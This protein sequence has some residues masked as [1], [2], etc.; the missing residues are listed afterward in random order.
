MAE[1]LSSRE[2]LMN[3]WQTLSYTNQKEAVELVQ[4]AKKPETRERRISKPSKWR[5]RS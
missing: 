4:S 3:A 5:R 2:G 1:A